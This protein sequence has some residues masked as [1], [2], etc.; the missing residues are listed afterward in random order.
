MITACPV[1]PRCPT[2]VNTTRF[3]RNARLTRPAEFQRVFSQPIKCNSQLFTFLATANGQ[4]RARLGL[5]VSKKNI[6]RAYA[7]NRIKRI[8][9]ESFRLTQSSIK[10]LDIVVLAR[11]GA[12]EVPRDTLRQ[13]LDKQWQSLA[14][15][16]ER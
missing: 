16:C 2:N 11:K 12:D 13:M 10:G 1:G 4:E 8:I 5:A 7:R 15:K 3:S 6:R 9:R 14:V